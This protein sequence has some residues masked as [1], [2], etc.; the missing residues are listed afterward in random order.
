MVILQSMPDTPMYK[1]SRNVRVKGFFDVFRIVHV[2]MRSILPMISVNQRVS[3]RSCVISAGSAWKVGMKNSLNVA[4]TCLE[5]IR[6]CEACEAAPPAHPVVTSMTAIQT[7]EIRP[8]LSQRRAGSMISSPGCLKEGAFLS[9]PL[10]E[11][12]RVLE[13]CLN[14]TVESWEVL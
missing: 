13:R 11:Q 4:R 2:V 9:L 12:Y 1:V 10:P 14:D 5:P 3:P 8:D 7:T 6:V